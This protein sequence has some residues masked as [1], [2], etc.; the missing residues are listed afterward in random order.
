MKER[1]KVETKIYEL[2]GIKKFKKAVFK[3]EKI[4]HRKDKEKNINYHVK[5]SRSKKS[6]NSFKKFLYYNGIIHIK[7][8]LIG[9]PSITIMALLNVK[10]IFLIPYAI[11]LLK[12]VY[13]VMLQRYNWIKINEFEEK[14]NSRQQKMIKKE[15]EQLKIEKL[16]TKLD[17]VKIDKQQMIDNLIAIRSYII[18]NN[19]TNNQIN[20]S[21]INIVEI[22]RN[23]NVKKRKLVNQNNLNRR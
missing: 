15:T 12:D 13:C 9:I 20:D 23:N 10:L 18:N 22:T 17:N 3:L 4:I 19:N 11:F 16:N 1:H 7:N 8:L 14:L 2:L 21:I 5:D 6:V